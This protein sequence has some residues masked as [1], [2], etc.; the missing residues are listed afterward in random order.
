MQQIGQQILANVRTCAD[1]GPCNHMA[2]VLVE[3][4]PGAATSA[5]IYGVLG[6][7]IPWAG[8]RSCRAP[9]ALVLDPRARVL[10]PGIQLGYLWV[11]YT[12]DP[13]VG[14]WPQQI[15]GRL[16]PRSQLMF[17]LTTQPEPGVHSPAPGPDSLL[18][19]LGYSQSSSQVCFM[20]VSDTKWHSL[21]GAELMKMEQRIKY[22]SI[23]ML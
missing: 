19:L 1:R 4:T 2:H 12:L 13:R 18:G 16:A 10:V 3:A 22:I 7:G 6:V 8:P 14:F 5:P 23:N 21:L 20:L 15:T 11:R 9:R 17:L